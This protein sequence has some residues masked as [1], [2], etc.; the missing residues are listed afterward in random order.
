MPSLMISP[1]Q[2]AS[3]QVYN[4]EAA[5]STTQSNN[6]QRSQNASYDDQLKNFIVP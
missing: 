2:I 6:H 5:G 3:D 1:F 4:E